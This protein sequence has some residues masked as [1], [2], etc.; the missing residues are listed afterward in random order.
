[1]QRGGV[2]PSG[3]WA[4]AREHAWQVTYSVRRSWQKVIGELDALGF[5]AKKN[6]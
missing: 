3:Q 6:P 1:M 2:Q 4:G 5:P